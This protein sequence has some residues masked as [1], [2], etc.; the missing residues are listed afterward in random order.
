MADTFTSPVKLKFRPESDSGKVRVR[1]SGQRIYNNRKFGNLGRHVS[2]SEKQQIVW[3]CATK[4][5]TFG[6]FV[7]ADNDTTRAGG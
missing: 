1:L 7:P 2:L 3:V 4:R 5:N 6:A